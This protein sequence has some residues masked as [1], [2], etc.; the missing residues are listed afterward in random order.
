ML[1]SVSFS[2]FSLLLQMAT[3]RAPDWSRAVQRLESALREE[4]QKHILSKDMPAPTSTAASQPAGG[5]SPSICFAQIT[6]D[7]PASLLEKLAT[8]ETVHHIRS[9]QDLKTRVFDSKRRVFALFHPDFPVSE[10]LAFIHVALMP[11]LNRD[12]DSIEKILGPVD[13][14]A[15]PVDAVLQPV[16]SAADI[17]ATAAIFY[18]VNAP[19]KGLTGMDVAHFLIKLTAQRLR[20]ELPDIVDFCTLSPMPGFAAWLDKELASELLRLAP[21][22]VTA[23]RE[24]AAFPNTQAQSNGRSRLFLKSEIAWL[25]RLRN[26]RALLP[27][28]PKPES[29]DANTQSDFICTSLFAKLLALGPPREPAPDSG[30]HAQGHSTAARDQ[31]VPAKAPSLLAAVVSAQNR[32][33]SEL[34]AT[35]SRRRALHGEAEIAAVLRPILLRLAVSYILPVAGSAKASSSSAQKS[36]PKSRDPVAK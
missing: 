1:S 30:P 32:P 15:S 14:P 16:V 17:A 33:R 4:I 26:A 21:A 9:L 3:T 20:Q 2:S 19:H 18:S 10:P 11:S 25:S 8:Y 29:A 36:V 7:S 5:L 22:K 23:G 12:A 31:P 34:Y 24:A 35:A 27:S 28:L 6:W 13:A